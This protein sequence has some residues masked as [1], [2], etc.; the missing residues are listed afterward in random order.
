[1]RG[2][3]D[4]LRTS[5]Q[6]QDFEII[7]VR[8]CESNG[9]TGR[10]ERRPSGLSRSGIPGKIPMNYQASTNGPR[11]MHCVARGVLAVDDEP[12]KLCEQPRCKLCYA[13]SNIDKLQVE[14]TRREICFD[15]SACAPARVRRPGG[16]QEGSVPHLATGFRDHDMTILGVKMTHNLWPA[17]GGAQRAKTVAV[18]GTTSGF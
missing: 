17:H 8:R 3:R 14:M 15:S 1:V 9:L 18:Q 4:H 10:E 12:I 6:A 13:E 5:Q 7:V 11:L 2:L 16:H